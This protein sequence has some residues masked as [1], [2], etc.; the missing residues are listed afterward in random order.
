[1]EG[2][3]GMQ[4]WR[5]L[6]LGAATLLICCVCHGA[7]AASVDGAL[8]DGRYEPAS[9]SFSGGTGR[10]EISCTTVQIEDGQ[11]KA[12]IVFSSPNYTCVK[13]DAETYDGIHDAQT[14]TF[15][16]PVVLGREFSIFAVSTAM[17]VAHEIE[18]RLNI[19]LSSG[20]ACGS[21]APMLNGLQPVSE[22]RPIAA[23]LFTVYRYE[24]GYT[25]IQVE[26]EMDCLVMPENQPLPEGLS[27]ETCVVQEPVQSAYLS[28]GQI[29]DALSSMD[30]N[31][32]DL[33]IQF[34]GFECEGS[35]MPYAGTESEPDYALLLKGGCDL[36]VAQAAALRPEGVRADLSER[37]NMLG[38]PLFVDCSS[39]ETSAQGRM[40]W[41]KVYGI[42]LGC[43]DAANAQFEAASEALKE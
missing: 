3:M 14:S 5:R 32:A 30:V 41:I 37:L 19:Q 38:I 40:E 34:L 2:G 33:P 6:L 1:M 25:L 24:G 36:F 9:F 11:A 21:E 42:L 26:G 12:E 28:G 13:V 23:R 4:M 10:V 22:E 18:Y 39:E 8:P 43:E 7:F 15:E 35:S 29:V 31:N 20:A 27:S 17:S 16:I